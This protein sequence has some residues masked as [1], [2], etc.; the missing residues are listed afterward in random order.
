VFPGA[1]EA[2]ESDQWWL[3]QDQARIAAD[4]GTEVSDLETIDQP[5]P[6]PFPS[7]D[8]APDDSAPT[9]APMTSESSAPR[10][11]HDLV[12]PSAASDL[13]SD[14]TNG[15]WEPAPAAHEEV[16]PSTVAMPSRSGR[17]RRAAAGASQQ[18]VRR[19]TPKKRRLS[20]D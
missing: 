4:Q 14:N 3:E 2:L 5:E 15:T 17:Y 10:T 7:R 11:I 19:W 6:T 20:P 13:A 9:S 12:R 16:T 8:V 1:T 18:P